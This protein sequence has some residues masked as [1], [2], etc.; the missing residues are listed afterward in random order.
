M[1]IIGTVVVFLSKI[2]AIISLIEIVISIIEITI[3]V[4]LQLKIE[5]FTY[6]ENLEMVINSFSSILYVSL[7]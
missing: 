4:L 1:T 5:I 6:S 7:F 2:Q 3:Y